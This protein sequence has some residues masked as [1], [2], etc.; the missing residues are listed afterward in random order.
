MESHRLLAFAAALTLA[1]SGTVAGAAGG[2]GGGSGG[3]SGSSTDGDM[4][5]EVLVKLRTTN[6]LVP[7][8]GK[9]SLT[10]VSRFGSRPIYRLKVIGS[11]RV[12]DV[13]A[14]LG[15]EPDVMI[16][17]T[18]PMH[19]EPESRRNIAWA[20]GTPQAFAT[21][22]APQAMHLADAQQIARGA[23]VTVAVLDTGV[24]FGHPLLAGR[25]LPGHDFVDDDNDPSE[26]GSAA[27][28]GFGHGTHV[29]GLVAMTAPGAKIMPLRVL[30]AGGVGNVWVLGEALL[31]AVDPDGN[32]ATA[33]GA[34]VI[35]MSLGSLARTRLFD[36]V[37]QIV[38]C[39]PSIPDDPVADLSDAGYDEDRVRCVG[40]NGAVVVA[41]AGNDASVSTK[42]YPAAEGSYGLL[43]VAASAANGKL[44]TFS[45]YGTWI[46]MAAPGD[47]I[48]SSVP[49]GGW[50]TWSGTSM[51]APLAAGTAALLR[52]A[53]PAMF[54][55]DVVKRI[56]RASAGL[57]GSSLRRVDALAALTDTV[58]PPP[59][60]P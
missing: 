11:A 12:K 17:E 18:N 42:Q 54:P 21:Q 3:G 37:A 49:G 30:D 41:A 43:A 33:D 52:S 22:W 26:V 8:L 56:K 10:L 40:G 45:N 15:S 6:A 59:T 27:D 24:D 53:A 16:A 44:A 9:Y 7:L 51:A 34:Q 50:G 2:G 55:A 38:A 25:L 36:T 47:A 13:I 48:T 5:G 35:N 32:P 19:Q 20:I 46:D 1:L 57:C 58:P 23:G 29:A 31:Y 28:L 39:Q 4:P 60:C 14:A